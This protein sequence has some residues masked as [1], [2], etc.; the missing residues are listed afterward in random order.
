MGSMD[1][2]STDENP[3]RLEGLPDDVEEALLDDA[4]GRE[5][6]GE[7]ADR[8]DLA[9]LRGGTRAHAGKSLR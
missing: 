8:G 7:A 9:G 1:R 4:L 5:V 2:V 6:L 3:C